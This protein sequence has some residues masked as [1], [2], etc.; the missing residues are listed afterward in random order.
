M[1]TPV[2]D[3]VFSMQAAIRR[4]YLVTYDVNGKTVPYTYIVNF[5]KY[6]DWRN[7]YKWPD[8]VCV[9]QLPENYGNPTQ[10]DSTVLINPYARFVLA[11]EVNHCVFR[12]EH[13]L[14]PKRRF[15]IPLTPSETA[16]I[17]VHPDGENAVQH[18]K[19]HNIYFLQKEDWI[20]TFC[21]LPSLWKEVSETEAKS[22]LNSDS[23]EVANLKKRIS[24][25]ETEIS[26]L[27]QENS[28]LKIKAMQKLAIAKGIVIITAIQ[29]RPVC[30]G[31]YCGKYGHECICDWMKI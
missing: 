22:R 19:N 18:F 7:N 4:G 17:I 23:S 14:A 16:Y 13:A 30:E 15:F 11:R 25:L 26:K 5:Q 31:C 9:G 21:S 1:Q 24:S 8:A 2:Y 10:V 27:H 6:G 12:H 20:Y 29:S 28:Q 3:A